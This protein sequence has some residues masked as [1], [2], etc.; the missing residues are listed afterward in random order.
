M[1]IPSAFR[2]FSVTGVSKLITCSFKSD[3]SR[4]NFIFKDLEALSKDL[5][6][7]TAAIQNEG[8][9]LGFLNLDMTTGLGERKL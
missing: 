8:Y 6:T 7:K 5:F 4:N 9:S 2:F 1:E 3:T